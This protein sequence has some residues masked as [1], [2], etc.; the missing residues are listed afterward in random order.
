MLLDTLT[1]RH[2]VQV[3]GTTHND[4]I[5]RSALEAFVDKEGTL[6][7][8]RIDKRGD[9]HVMVSYSEEAM[10]ERPRGALR[11][12]RMSTKIVRSKL[13]IVEGRDEEMFFDAALQ[14][15]LALADIQ[16][17]PIGGK[18]KLTQNLSGLVNDL[19]FVT[20]Q[21]LAILRDADADRSRR[22]R[23]FGDPGVPIRLRLVATR[24]SPCS[25]RP[26][27]VCSWPAACGHLHHPE[28][29]R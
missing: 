23:R 9:R 3:F 15:H 14:D 7:L 21:S 24:R 28:R 13:L 2:H 27:P 26:W 22:D 12:A 29:S 17:L 16:I 1:E 4:D 10:R 18:T 25:D 11:G 19:D 8:F 6:G 5:I 20:V